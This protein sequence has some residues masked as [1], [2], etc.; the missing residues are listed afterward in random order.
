MTVHDPLYGP[1]SIPDYLQEFVMA[2]EVRRLSQ[3]R[4]LNTLTPSLATL[5]ELRRYSHTLGV[6]HLCS[7]NTSAGFSTLERQALAVSV[8]LHDIGTPPFGH[9]MEYHLRETHKWSHETI[10]RAIIDGCHAPENRAHQIFA[11]RVIEFGTILRAS[12][13]PLDLVKRIVTGQHPLATLL[14]GSVDLDNVD[15]VIRM[16]WALGLSVSGTLGIRL[17]SLVRVSPDS[18]LLAVREEA[19]EALQRWA[20]MRRAVYDILVFDPETVSAQA[21]LS[22]AIERAFALDELGMDDWSLSDEQLLERL[23]RLPDT[24]NAI[25]LEYLGRLPW[26]AFCIQIS[27]T[28]ESLSVGGRQ[29]LKTLIEDALAVHFGTKRGLGYVFSDNGSFEK[30][31]VFFDDSTKATWELGLSSRSV[32]LYGFVRGQKRS[33][34]RSTKACETLLGR[35]GLP[36][37]R[38]MRC[39]ITESINHIHAPSTLDF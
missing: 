39:T 8:L 7:Q 2:P 17:A 35:L 32:V 19:E 11:G 33:V 22:D 31:L 36:P 13:I 28:I 26:L 34:S 29:P 30:H 16:A 6:L 18:Q 37:N 15:N 25:T 3:I 27:G 12:K 5:G 14:F 1:I 4:L 24:K 10:I 9:L 23:R 38:L 21:V 20:Q